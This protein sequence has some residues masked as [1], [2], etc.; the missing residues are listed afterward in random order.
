MICVVPIYNDEIYIV[1]FKRE[2]YID[3]LYI[4]AALTSEESQFEMETT[5]K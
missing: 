5:R 1:L 3:T 2:T 4:D